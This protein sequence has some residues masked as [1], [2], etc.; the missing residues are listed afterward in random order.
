[1]L[2]NGFELLDVL[3][4]PNI[5]IIEIPNTNKAAKIAVFNVR[6]QKADNFLLMVTPYKFLSVVIVRNS[7]QPT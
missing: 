1:M 7:R 4:C 2:I 5:V 3:L 6:P